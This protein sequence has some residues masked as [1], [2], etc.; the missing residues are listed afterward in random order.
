MAM[1][2]PSL[3]VAPSSV[4]VFVSVSF[5]PPPPTWLLS[6]QSAVP[7]VLPFGQVG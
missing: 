6:N 7:H 3:C 1:E 5:L 4:F 2:L